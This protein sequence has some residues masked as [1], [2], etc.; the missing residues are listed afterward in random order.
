MTPHAAFIVGF[1]DKQ[2]VRA[3]FEPAIA[4]REP[5]QPVILV[6]LLEE[7]SGFNLA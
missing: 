2:T 1:F 3:S 6:K 4:T 5:G 7:D